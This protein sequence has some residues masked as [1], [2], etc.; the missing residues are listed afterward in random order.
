MILKSTNNEQRERVSNIDMIKLPREEKPKQGNGTITKNYYSRC[1]WKFL[2]N[3]LNLDIN[4]VNGIPGEK[5]KPEI[6]TLIHSLVKIISLE[7]Q[8][9]IFYT[10]MKTGPNNF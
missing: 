3:Y 5:I 10:L 4:E 6:S 1:H 7:R 8:K 2:K 9:I